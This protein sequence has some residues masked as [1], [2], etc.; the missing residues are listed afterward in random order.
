M[1]KV[2]FVYNPNAGKAAM[3]NKL[4]DVMTIFRKADFEVTV[5]PT[6]ESQDATR[7]VQEK[8][9][10]Y[11]RVICAGGDG[12]LHEVTHGLMELTP[13]ERPKCGYIPTGTVN[14]F[15]TGIKL[16]KRVL[17]A[18][19]IAAG[20]K[21]HAYDV[22]ELNGSYFTY[23]AAFGAF[24]SVAY[25]TPQAT[26]NLLGKP[27]YILNGVVK[28]NT[29]KSVHVR[30]ETEEEIWEDDCVLGMVT[31]AKSVGGMNLYRSKKVYLDDGY[32][33]GIFVK[34]PRNPIELNLV[35]SFLLTGESNAQIKMLGG[36]QFIINADEEIAYTLDGEDGGQ[37]KKAVITSHKQA[38]TYFHGLD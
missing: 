32:F 13:K 2:L 6:L 9:R 37:H 19:E 8:G 15:A 26:K 34:T 33:D 11:D 36:S 35:I 4:S 18:A 31:N 7:I 24:T 16:P 17:K 14:D 20:D 29:I 27:A 10:Q 28:L 12:T 23:V 5:Y 3:K 1:E 38:I 25:E 21:Y 22:G 30:V